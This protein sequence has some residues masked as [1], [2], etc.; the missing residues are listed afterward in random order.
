MSQELLVS[1]C[2]GWV[3]LG[4]IA[5]KTIGEVSQLVWC[6]LREV[7]QIFMALSSITRLIREAISFPFPSRALMSSQPDIY[8]WYLLPSHSGQMF[9]NHMFVT[10]GHISMRKK[11]E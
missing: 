10:R 6:E 8:L 5:A 3:S 1:F 7:L 4:T 11:K 9:V 2:V